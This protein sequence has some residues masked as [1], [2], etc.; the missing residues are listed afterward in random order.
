MQ[1]RTNFNLAVIKNKIKNLAA[2]SESRLD[3][4]RSILEQK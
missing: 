3:F 2:D 1:W 4:F